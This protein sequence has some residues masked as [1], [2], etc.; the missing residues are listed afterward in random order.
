MPK[1]QFEDKTAKAWVIKMTNE[2][3]SILKVLYRLYI[4]A[5]QTGKAFHAIAISATPDSETA[6]EF[7]KMANIAFKHAQIYYKAGLKSI[8]QNRRQYPEQERRQRRERRQIK[9]P[10]SGLDRRKYI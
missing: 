6:R 1:Q 5:K 10:Y 4:K 7:K 9:L 2:E 3:L 8:G